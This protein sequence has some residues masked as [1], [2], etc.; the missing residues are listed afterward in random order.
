[1]TQKVEFR[2][3]THKELYEQLNT[4]NEYLRQVISFESKV[5][6]LQQ[7]PIKSWQEYFSNDLYCEMIN[8]AHLMLGEKEINELYDDFKNSRNNEL[9]KLIFI[10]KNIS[11]DLI[12][13]NCDPILLDDYRLTYKSSFKDLT[14]HEVKNLKFL[15][16]I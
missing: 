12:L 14:K 2:K 1:M 8:E 6:K 10:T 16:E 4:L 7:H 3:E 5:I 15:R 11:D 13:K 9:K